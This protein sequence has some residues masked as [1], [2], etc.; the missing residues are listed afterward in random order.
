[1]QGNLVNILISMP[2]LTI[3]HKQKLWISTKVPKLVACQCDRTGRL[4]H[5]F[6]LC[7]SMGEG[8][9]SFK[10]GSQNVT[11][12]MQR[13]KGTFYMIPLKQKPSILAARGQK[14]SYWLLSWWEV[15]GLKR[16]PT[17]SRPSPGDQSI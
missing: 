12:T 16:T 9:V 5:S 14:M 2:E 6:I 1:L 15:G 17:G 13:M 11:G 8:H 4:G 3:A 7:R 10:R